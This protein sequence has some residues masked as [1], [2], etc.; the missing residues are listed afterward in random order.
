MPPIHRLTDSRICG[1]TT[2]VV[3]NSTV[4]ANNLLVAVDKDPNIHGAGNLIAACREVYAHNIL[5]VNHTPDNAIPDSLCIP[6]G[7]LHCGPMTAQ[8]SP[9]VFTGD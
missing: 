1:A 9:N 7:G 3:G 6:V 4:Y 8:G 5:T 2:V